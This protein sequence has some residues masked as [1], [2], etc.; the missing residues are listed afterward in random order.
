[1]RQHRLQ[2]A[3]ARPNESSFFTTPRSRARTSPNV[4]LS[5]LFRFSNYYRILLR[6][7]IQ[8]SN[9]KI[10]SLVRVRIARVRS[11]HEKAKKKK[12]KRKRTLP[13][14]CR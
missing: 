12:K 14:E 8:I 5:D 9:T 1:M 10:V 13:I 7:L 4:S 6:R 11:V 3:S 2:A